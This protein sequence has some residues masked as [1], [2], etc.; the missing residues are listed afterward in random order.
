MQN[1][2]LLEDNQTLSETIVYSLTSPS[3]KI[4]PAPTL[5]KA[6]DLLNQTKFDL[7]IVDRIVE[8]GD[9]I[10]L[11]EYLSQ[12][13]TNLHV[14]IISHKTKVAEKLEG[15]RSGALD[16][17]SKPFHLEELRLKSQ[18]LLNLNRNNRAGTLQVGSIQLDQ[19][20]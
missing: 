18:Q 10:E 1:V 19:A 6:Y 4:H 12:E 13:L 2:L 5:E 9:G 17:L 3:T 11:V 20:E 15:L 8:D 7:A 16:Y 14:L